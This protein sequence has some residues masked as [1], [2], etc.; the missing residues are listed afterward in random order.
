[1]KMYAERDQLLYSQEYDVLKKIDPLATLLTDA[2][3]SSTNWESAF[4][5]A[6]EI[7]LQRAL[8]LCEDE[9]DASE[10]NFK[11]TQVERKLW[12]NPF[13][14]QKSE[15]FSAKIQNNSLLF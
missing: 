1:M 8:L 2:L 15:D 14:I 11:L 4:K 9:N 6:S 7:K 10:M 13:L 12:I 3:S 5:D